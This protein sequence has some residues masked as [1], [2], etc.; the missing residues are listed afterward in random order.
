MTPA[1]AKRDRTRV[2]LAFAAVYV[3]WGS[4]YL[5]MKYA[6]ETIPPFLLGASRFVVAGLILYLAARARGAPDAT[7]SEWQ[8]A[9]VTGLLMLGVGNGAV[10]WSV[11]FVPSGLAALVVA[12]VPLWIALFDWIR[13]RGRRP[14]PAVFVG[15]GLGLLGMVTL[16]GPRAIIGEG[17]IDALGAAVLVV[18]SMSW[19]FGSIVTRS[20]GHPR[21]PL[22][23]TAL[24][25]LAAGV[26]FTIVALASG[27]LRAFS[28][29]AVTPKSLLGW[30]YLVVAGSLIGFTAYIYLLGKV[31][32]AK[33]A[34]YA[35]VNPVIAVILG[36]AFANEP[37]GARTLIAATV[38]LAGVAMITATQ[39]SGPHT[40]EHP[41]PS[42]AREG[43]R[44][45]A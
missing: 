11:Q 35:Y 23:S 42:G 39:S 7:R 16:V 36:W 34:T 14:R 30:V 15:L 29:G 22:V 13:P 1:T 37:L 45:A 20:S 6:V 28:V 40:G 43:Q 31:S 41:L 10:M 32:A 17:N 12:T 8:V 21:S 3:L 5:F 24:Q 19:A 33:A 4:T 25:M 27:E 18:G 44:T 9:V 38:I 2:I 26:A